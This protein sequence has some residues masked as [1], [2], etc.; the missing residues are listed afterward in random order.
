MKNLLFLPLLLIS[1]GSLVHHNGNNSDSEAPEV[2]SDRLDFHGYVQT[3]FE[4]TVD[5]VQFN[6]SEHFYTRFIQDLITPNY[7]ELEGKEIEVLGTYGI[8]TFGTNSPVFVAPSGSDGHLYSATTD[9][10]RHFEVVVSGSSTGTYRSK[11]VNRIGLLIDGEKSCYLLTSTKDNITFE[12][13]VPIVFSE[14]TTQLN[15][16]KCEVGTNSIEIPGAAG[17]SLG[18]IRL[19]ISTEEEVNQVMGNPGLKTGNILIYSAESGNCEPP[20]AECKIHFTLSDTIDFS[21]SI[22]ESLIWR[23]TGMVIQ[24]D[25]TELEVATAFGAPYNNINGMFTYESK[26]GVCDQTV[27]VGDRS[28]CRIVWGQFTAPTFLAPQFME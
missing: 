11:L 22:K 28:I 10:S 14:Y 19:G 5:G 23:P 7:P 12:R 25:S 27:S 13:E 8:S 16:Y 3:A 4:I 1:C 2:S 18:L 21:E 24:P 17:S 20:A 15:T 9:S 26:S 6:D